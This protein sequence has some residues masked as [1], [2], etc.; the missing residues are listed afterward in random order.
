MEKAREA[1]EIYS[2]PTPIPPADATW[3]DVQ[4]VEVSSIYMSFLEWSIFIGGLG[5]VH[6]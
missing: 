2:T 6:Y 4:S 3:L 5:P 1:D